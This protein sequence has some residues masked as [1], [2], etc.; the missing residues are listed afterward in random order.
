MLFWPDK[1]ARMIPVEGR[2]EYVQVQNVAANTDGGA[3]Y[4]F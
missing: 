1:A 4:Q 3:T 2:M